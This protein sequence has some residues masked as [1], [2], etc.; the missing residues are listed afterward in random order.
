MPVI[1]VSCSIGDFGLFAVF[2]CIAASSQTGALTLALTAH[3][4][5]PTGHDA[6]VAAYI[7]DI[8]RTT[9]LHDHSN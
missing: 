8:R 6:A 7:A 3:S 9:E 2:G 1:H 4:C 5:T